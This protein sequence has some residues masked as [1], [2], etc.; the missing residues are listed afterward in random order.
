MQVS[1]QRWCAGL[2]LAVVC[3]AAVPLAGRAADWPFWGRNASRNM[4]SGETGVPT[5]FEAGKYKGATEE[6]DLATTKNVKWVVKLGSQTYGNPTVAGG[7]VYIGTNNETPR[8]PNLKGDRAVLMCLDEKTGDLPDGLPT[9]ALNLALPPPRWR[10]PHQRTLSPKSRPST[11]PGRHHGR[12]GPHLRPHLVAVP[13][14]RRPRSDPWVGEHPVE[15][16][17]RPHGGQQHPAGAKSLT[18]DLPPYLAGYGYLPAY[19]DGVLERVSDYHGEV[20]LPEGAAAPHIG[21]VVAVIPNHVCPVIDL[22]DSF[23]ATRNGTVIGRW[24]VDARG[25]SG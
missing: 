10:L 12:L 6:I 17:R 13:R 25:R 2:A 7:R 22:F 5:A 23:V 8:D 11:L 20:R 16:S 24:P 21:D 15:P 14:V 4:V 19:P 1:K 9:P 18:K 3:C